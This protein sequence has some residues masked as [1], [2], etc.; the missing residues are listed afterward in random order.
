MERPLFPFKWNGMEV[1]LFFSLLLYED[2][3]F[4]A[5]Q[6]C[7]KFIL[8][9]RVKQRLVYPYK[10]IQWTIDSARV[11]DFSHVHK[12]DVTIFVLASAVQQL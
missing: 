10:L 4:Q 7:E 8:L 6:V 11:T 3:G 1:S 12:M 5:F 2:P 9:R